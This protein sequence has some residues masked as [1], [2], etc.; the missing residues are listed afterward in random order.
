MCFR[1]N[2]VVFPTQGRG[3]WGVVG[4]P[5]ADGGEPARA[6]PF[7]PAGAAVGVARVER[8]GGGAASDEGAISIEEPSTFIS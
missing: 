3:V 5:A 6:E 7:Q 2:F 4:P 8:H 1:L